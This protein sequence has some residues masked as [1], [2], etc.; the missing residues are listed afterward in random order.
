M[1]RCGYL[2]LVII[3]L[4]TYVYSVKLQTKIQNKYILLG[5][6]GYVNDIPYKDTTN[7][8]VPLSEKKTEIQNLENISLPMRIKPEEANTDHPGNGSP[9]NRKWGLPQEF[10]P[11]QAVYEIDREVKKYPKGMRIKFSL[12]APGDIPLPKNKIRLDGRI[13]LDS[14]ENNKVG[15]GAQTNQSTQSQTNS[16]NKVNSD[17]STNSNGVSNQTGNQNVNPLTD[18][19]NIPGGESTDVGTNAHFVILHPT[20][21]NR[22]ASDINLGNNNNAESHTSSH[23]EVD[24]NSTGTTGSSSSNHS[25]FNSADGQVVTNSHSSSTLVSEPING[26]SSTNEFLVRKPINGRGQNSLSNDVDVFSSNSNSNGSNN[27]AT[28]TPPPAPVVTT[29]APTPTYTPPTSYNA[30]TSTPTPTYVAPSPST[31]P[32]YTPPTTTTTT[33]NPEPTPTVT[34][35][36]TPTTTSHATNTDESYLGF[37]GRSQVNGTLDNTII[38]NNTGRNLTLANST[39]DSSFLKTSLLSIMVI[40]LG[41]LI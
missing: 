7:F 3:I 31:A 36:I 26:A 35:T 16:D 15:S 17:S 39:G 12:E 40:A 23:S 1:N 30:P 13:I 10:V 28:T 37:T 25:S 2:C 27:S 29:P 20:E 38:M 5:E 11:Q 18:L 22:S 34:P 32:T 14:G 41:I 24:P 33:T 8:G 4:C 9:T 21:N 19:H 6:H